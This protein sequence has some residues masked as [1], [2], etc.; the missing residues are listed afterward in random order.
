ML[1]TIATCESPPRMCPTSAAANARSRRV[2]PPVFINSPARKKNGIARNANESMPWISVEARTLK[3]TCPP[4]ARMN[5]SD[6]SP[7]A[8]NTGTPS[9]NSARNAPIRT[10][11]GRSC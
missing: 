4:I 3:G 2:I 10:P 5:D 11:K 6:A 9:A 8:K 1:A 7:I